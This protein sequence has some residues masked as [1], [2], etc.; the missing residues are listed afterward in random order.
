MITSKAQL[1]T[2]QKAALANDVPLNNIIV[3]D[4][5]D[6]ADYISLEALLQVEEK[7]WRVF[8]SADTSRSATAALMTTSGTTGMPKMAARSHLSWVAENQAIEDLCEKPYIV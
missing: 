1:E 3:I 6:N 4:G 2:V 8:C 5:S 7:P